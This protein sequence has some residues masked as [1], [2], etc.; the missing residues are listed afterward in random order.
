MVT[1]RPVENEVG[2]IAVRAGQ[3]QRTV[4]AHD[5]DQDA[6]VVWCA[7]DDG[8]V[9]EAAVLQGADGHGYV[10][11]LVDEGLTGFST[12]MAGN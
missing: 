2:G 5:V 1:V 7:A 9:D 4:S 10:R 3:L 12:V 6:G 11:S 8:D